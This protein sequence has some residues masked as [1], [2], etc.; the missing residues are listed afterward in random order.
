MMVIIW[1]V[2]TLATWVGIPV[3]IIYVVRRFLRA[4]EQRTVTIAGAIARVDAF[5]RR[6]AH[7]E[8]QLSTG[9]PQSPPG[10]RAT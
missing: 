2:L 1:W 7:L 6:L 9:R 4:Y 5:E 10:S 3:A 8:A